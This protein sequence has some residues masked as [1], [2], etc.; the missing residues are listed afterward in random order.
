MNTSMEIRNKKINEFDIESKL[1][2]GLV[3]VGNEIKAV[4]SNQVDLTGAWVNVGR[5][6]KNHIPLLINSHFKQ[7]PKHGFLDSSDY[8]ANRDRKLLLNKNEIRFLN[9]EVQKGRSVI[10]IRIYLSNKKYKLELAV[11]RPL[12]K[13]DKREKE[14][15][16]ISKREIRDKC[17]YSY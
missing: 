2:A 13:W 6:G 12:K 8:E 17:K 7:F 9:Q 3:L 14:K 10:P 1:E 5:H 4:I 16:E 15:E 11:C